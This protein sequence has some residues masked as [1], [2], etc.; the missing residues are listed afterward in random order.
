MSGSQALLSLGAVALFMYLS[1]NINRAYVNASSQ[2]VDT[3][4]RVEA[5]NYGVTLAQELYSQSF[6]Y[7][8]LDTY[9]GT[10]N[11]IED[12]GQRK[13]YVT[14]TGDSLVATVEL[15]SEQVLLMGVNGR[16]ATITVFLKDDGEYQELSTHTASI[17][18][19][20]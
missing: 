11:D 3:Q 5:V 2:T 16:V 17:I 19:F 4:H 18:S 14:I 20:N 15:S 12:P 9:Y 7:D 13:N 8:S 1:M 10:L 6:N